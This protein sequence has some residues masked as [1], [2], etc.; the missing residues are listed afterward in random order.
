[1]YDVF[2]GDSTNN[3]QIV[4]TTATINETTEIPI[5]E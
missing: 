5:G 4:E 3:R 1:M 2:L